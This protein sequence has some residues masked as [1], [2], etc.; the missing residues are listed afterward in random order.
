MTRANYL[1]RPWGVPGFPLQNSI[2]EFRSVNPYDGCP[3]G[4]PIGVGSPMCLPMRW[5]A[6]RN[7][8]APGADFFDQFFPS[9]IFERDVG[10]TPELPLWYNAAGNVRSMRLIG[11]FLY[12]GPGQPTGIL[13]FDMDTQFPAQNVAASEQIFETFDSNEHNLSFLLKFDC[14]FEPDCDGIYEEFIGLNPIYQ[15][16]PGTSFVQPPP[17]VP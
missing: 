11:R 5:I 4:R 6:I 3:G 14:E 15:S 8:Q 13:R 10:P 9:L 2:P 7:E 1:E 17:I 16:E 12:P